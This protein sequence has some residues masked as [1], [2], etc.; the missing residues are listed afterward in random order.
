MLTENHIKEGLSRAYILAVAHRAGVN[1]SVREFDYGIDGTFHDVRIRDGRR[2]ESGF[3]LDFQAKA[4]DGCEI[5][6]H[7]VVYDLE[8]KSHRD[9]TDP[10]GTARILI[11][12][13]LPKDPNEWLAVS[14]DA[15]VLKR[16]AW[17]LSLRGQVPTTNEK[18]QRIKIPIAQRFDVAALVGMMARLKGGGLP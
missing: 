11:V 12:L 8:A 6:D 2:V 13:A 5:G 1:C 18:K 3:P 9:L 4:S 10:E 14:P 15:L 7:E 16:C 17:W